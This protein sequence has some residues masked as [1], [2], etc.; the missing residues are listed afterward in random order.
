[1]DDQIVAGAI[2]TNDIDTIVDVLEQ[3]SFQ[4]DGYVKV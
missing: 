3:L 2:E 4:T 1:M